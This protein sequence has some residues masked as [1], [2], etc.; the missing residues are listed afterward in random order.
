MSKNKTIL[1]LLIIFYLISIQ[2]KT[3]TWY[4]DSYEL[5]DYETHE[6]F[7]SSFEVNKSGFIFR[8]GNEIT[9]DDKFDENKKELLLQI[10]KNEDS[11]YEFIRN[12]CQFD[13]NNLIKSLN[14]CWFL[15]KRSRMGDFAIKYKVNEGDILRFG[16]VIIRIKEIKINKNK[17]EIVNNNEN[18]EIDYK[19]QK[20]KIHK[21]TKK[22]TE[23]NLHVLTLSKGVHK[24]KDS[25]I[26]YIRDK[27][28]YNNL[29]LKDICNSNK[30]GNIKLP[31]VCRIC[32]GEEN[33]LEYYDNPL[34]QPCKCSG[35]LKYIHLNC[36]KQ[37]LNT[38]SCI[39]I[40]SNNNF[41]FFLIKPVE[42]ELC[43]T[44]FPDFIRHNG[45]LYEILDFKSEFEYYCIMESLTIDKN[46]NK[47]IYV[48]SLNSNKKLKIG[49]GHDSDLIL[50]DISVSR[51]HG[52]LI[53]ENKNIYIEDN[54][55]KF[56]T[57][58]LMQTPSIKLVNNLPLFIQ[59]GRTFLD[60]RIKKIEKLFS[61]CQIFDS[62]N[63][64]HYHIQNEKNLM[65][66]KMVTIKTEID[67][68]E[69][70]KEINDNEIFK[71]E[72]NEKQINKRFEDKKSEKDKI[73]A[74]LRLSLNDNNN[75]DNN[76]DN[77]NEFN[78]TTYKKYRLSLY[79]NNTSD[80]KLSQNLIDNKEDSLAKGE[81][82]DL[83][84]ENKSEFKGNE[85][86]NVIP[87]NRKNY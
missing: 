33:P 64:N 74:K 47:F 12:E 39:K 61:C 86:I 87:L 6:L 52:I 66:Q 38:K 83:E 24:Y 76:S 50:G 81:S 22:K 19:N 67:E 53:I 11:N 45:K 5:I 62:P 37:W 30:R 36:L 70:E 44:K 41:S 28:I 51:I 71:D 20:I 57:L 9:F 10:N 34:V 42:C 25:N 17:K 32:Y 23:P 8:N 65:G 80:K 55:S 31:K 18:D 85:D 7:F 68:V 2:I 78:L 27:I 16:R 72:I 58:V 73:Y 63:L 35:S 59:V 4:K 48:V 75:D 60:C 43:K 40:E 79:S 21:I 26:N 54:N 46:N 84:N 13:D 3:E 29:H 69:N 77:I 82:I 49:R 14:T 56:G 15:F 1:Y